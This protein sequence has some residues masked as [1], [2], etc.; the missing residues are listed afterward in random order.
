MTARVV[1]PTKLSPEKQLCGVPA[2]WNKSASALLLERSLPM[3]ARR[4]DGSTVLV[5]GATEPVRL[6]MCRRHR[7]RFTL[8]WWAACNFMRWAG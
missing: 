1:V 4:V 7:E 2:C 6:P 3:G 8:L 5:G